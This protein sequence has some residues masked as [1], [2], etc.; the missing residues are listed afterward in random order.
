VVVL[1]R[2]ERDPDAEPLG[3]LDQVHPRPR[4]RRG[5]DVERGQDAAEPGPD[6]GDVKPAHTQVANDGSSGWSDLA[7]IYSYFISMCF[8]CQNFYPAAICI[9]ACDDAG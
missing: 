6:N 5:Q 7:V 4:A 2:A 3:L 8:R 1:A 9:W